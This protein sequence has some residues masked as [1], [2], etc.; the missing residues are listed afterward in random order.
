MYDISFLHCYVD[1]DEVRRTKL[2][3]ITLP[4]ITLPWFKEGDDQE[5]KDE[6][7]GRDNEESKD[8]GGRD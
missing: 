1:P 7:G 8:E 6:G 3:R 2:P 5:S 4:Q